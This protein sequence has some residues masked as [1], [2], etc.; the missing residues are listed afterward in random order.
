MSVC[1]LLI[2]LNIPLISSHPHP[3][4][5]DLVDDD[6]WLRLRLRQ[7]VKHSRH[8]NNSGNKMSDWN[9]NLYLYLLDSFLKKRIT[10]TLE[11]EV[12]G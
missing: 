9:F 7:G 1:C 2:P 12:Q 3:F 6:T 5:S 10:I 4:T 8:L 11:L